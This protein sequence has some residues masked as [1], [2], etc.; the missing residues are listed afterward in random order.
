MWI[1]DSPSEEEAASESSEQH[2]TRNN[3]NDEVKMLSTKMLSALDNELN[4]A[5]QKKLNIRQNFFSSHRILTPRKL[6][7]F[8][9][10][11]I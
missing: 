4:R 8:M 6:K 3:L 1:I 5:V 2:E 9:S 11:L 10:H 7:Y